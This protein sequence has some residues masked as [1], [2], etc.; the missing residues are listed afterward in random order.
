MLCFFSGALSRTFLVWKAAWFPFRSRYL[1]PSD[2]LPLWNCAGALGS[3]PVAFLWFMA[4]K[5]GADR[6]LP[7]R[8]SAL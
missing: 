7:G 8:T 5:T 3:F 4:E 2:V 1:A 6:V